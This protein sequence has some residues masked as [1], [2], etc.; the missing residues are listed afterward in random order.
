MIF[1]K[2]PF[3]DDYNPILYV[4]VIYVY[5]YDIDLCVVELYYTV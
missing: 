3:L 1:G 5:I 2:K 4:I